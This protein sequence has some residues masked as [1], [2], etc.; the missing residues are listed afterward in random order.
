MVFRSHK[1]I[2]AVS[3]YGVADD[4]EVK[5]KVASVLS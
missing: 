5:D 4:D 1:L 3:S 2:G